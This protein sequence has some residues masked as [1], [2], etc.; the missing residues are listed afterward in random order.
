MLEALYYL[1]LI[2]PK[3][4][5][6]EVCAKRSLAQSKKANKMFPVVGSKATPGG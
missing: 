1:H 3:F 5:Q 6:S 2:K 4:D